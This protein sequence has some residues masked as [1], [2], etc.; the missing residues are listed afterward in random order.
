MRWVPVV[1]AVAATSL[2]A[3]GCAMGWNGERIEGSGNLAEREEA[4]GGIRG[5]ALSLAGEISIM[6]GDEERLVMRGEDNILDNI[7]VR[8]DDG[9]VYIQPV[10]GADLRPTKPISMDLTI[11]TLEDLA[12]SGSAEV[13]V[14]PL[15]VEAL[16]VAVSGSGD[17]DLASL[18]CE[19]L[20][21]AISG[22][23][24]V[25]VSDG[26]AAT[27]RIAISGSGDY[28]GDALSSVRA[29]VAVS[30]SGSAE[31]HVTDSLEAAVSG[32][33][34]ITYSGDPESVSQE[35]SGS[36][37]ITASSVGA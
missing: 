18:R 35:V 26:E 24:T 10:E 1:L 12:C 15:D 25:A 11:G 32:S 8:V 23:G 7:Q 33:G 20:A 2:C 28:R 4:L 30:G 29:A 6:I 5:V 13:A 31:V 34:R 27:Q 37:R 19:L 21:V 36:G 17:V 3:A 22:S 16:S 9:T 14:A